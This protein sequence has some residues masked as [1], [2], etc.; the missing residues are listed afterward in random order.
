[1]YISIYKVSQKTLQYGYTVLREQFLLNFH[2][3]GVIGK[4]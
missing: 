4:L 2:N 3:Q 1:M